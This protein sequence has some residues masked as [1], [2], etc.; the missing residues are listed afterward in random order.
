MSSRRRTI[1]LS[2]ALS[3]V[4]PFLGSCGAIPPG[5]RAPQA[6]QT[7]AEPQLSAPQ[8]PPEDGSAL[9]A[10]RV[11]PNATFKVPEASPSEPTVA[12]TAQQQKA[13]ISAGAS[14]PG[15]SPCQMDNASKPEIS[16]VSLAVALQNQ[17][18]A[19]RPSEK[20]DE[21]EL[22]AEKILAGVK[23]M[24]RGES[25]Q[26]S[27]P[28]PSDQVTVETGSI[29]VK[30][31]G[32]T[33]GLLPTAVSNGNDI[34]VSRYVKNMGLI[35]SQTTFAGTRT[36]E[37]DE[38]FIL[39]VRARGGDYA[40]WPKGF[41]QLTLRLDREHKQ[42]SKRKKSVAPELAVLFAARLQSPYLIQEASHQ[43]PRPD[44]PH[45][46]TSRMTVV[47]IELA[48]AALIDRAKNIAL[49]PITIGP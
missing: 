38:E 34:I 3:A 8:S 20:S 44:F 16:I 33:G 18:L 31:H 27:V 25:F 39:A 46:I 26:F 47:V 19:R 17:D 1:L 11:Q 13:P 29:T 32:V 2:L 10:Q 12:E 41:K 9:T 30:P 42:S 15:S 35:N 14:A 37:K 48:C 43:S 45:D 4:S 7:A 22:R 21:F 24:T 40:R 28:V 36:I 5:E 6:A 23:Q 49:A